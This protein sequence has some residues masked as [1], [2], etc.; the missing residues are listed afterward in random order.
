MKNEVG[1]FYGEEGP[2]RLCQREDMLKDVTPALASL[3]AD[4][5]VFDFWQ[6][7]AK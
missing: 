7:H 1:C 3:H 4:D 6:L 2:G 5:G